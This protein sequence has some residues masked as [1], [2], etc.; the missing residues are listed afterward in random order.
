M[1]PN[2]VGSIYG[3]FC[4]KFSQSRMKGEWQARPTEPLVFIYIYELGKKCESRLKR[5]LN[6]LNKWS[7]WQNK[8][9]DLFK[10]YFCFYFQSQ[11]Y[12]TLVFNTEGSCISPLIRT[13]DS[14]SWYTDIEGCGIKCQNPL[15]TDD[16]HNQVHIIIA[17]FGSICITCTLFTVVSFP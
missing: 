4:I 9:L 8:M 15:Y 12:D 6:M 3:R 16:E 17:I 5:P 13:E 11:A 10:N 7:I 1:N 14:E 2:L